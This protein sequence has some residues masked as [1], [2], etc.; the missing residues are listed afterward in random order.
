MHPTAPLEANRGASHVC[1]ELSGLM[2]GSS[3]SNSD[4]L[5]RWESQMFTFKLKVNPILCREDCGQ[6]PNPLQTPGREDNGVNISHLGK[7]HLQVIGVGARGNK[8]GTLALLL[9]TSLRPS[10][11]CV[12]GSVAQVHRGVACPVRRSSG[13]P[14]WLLCVFPQGGG[15]QG[16]CPGD[17]HLISHG[18]L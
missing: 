13:L 3:S 11:R 9:K 7:P 14:G 1:P 5:C 10:V 15:K 8:H 17:V 12:S 6:H 4:V 2:S 18:P 16:G